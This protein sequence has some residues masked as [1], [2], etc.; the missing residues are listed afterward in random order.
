[1]LTTCRYFADMTP[2]LAP[3]LASKLIILSILILVHTQGQELTT[4]AVLD[5]EAFGISQVESAVLTNRMRSGLVM[6]GKVTVVERHGGRIWA[7]SV[8]GEGSTFF[9]TIAGEESILSG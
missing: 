2:P 6:T 7:E 8:P 4:L 5:F 3:K 1:M 9:F